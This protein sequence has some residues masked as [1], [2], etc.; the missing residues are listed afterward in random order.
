MFADL[1][2][3]IVPLVLLAIPYS[4]FANDSM[5]ASVDKWTGWIVLA[6][7]LVIRFFSSN[8]SNNAKV[9]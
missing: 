5:L 6:A 9:D 4:P 1:R 2:Y 8:R 7:I 3:Y